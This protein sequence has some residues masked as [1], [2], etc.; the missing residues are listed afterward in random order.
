VGSWNPDRRREVD[1]AYGAFLLVRR[2]FF[3]LVGGFDETQWMYAEDIDIAWRLKKS[4]HPV[5]YE[6]RAVVRHAFSASARQAFGDLERDRRHM[7]A[8]YAWLARRRGVAVA[9]L[10]AAL[11]FAGAVLRLLILSPL[12]QV[13]PRQWKAPRELARRYVSLHR[14][15]LRGGAPDGTG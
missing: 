4:G 7:T 2:E 6:P 15:G 14:A 3:E 9:R 13:A 8:S 5:L 1:W 10:T 11:N 12:A